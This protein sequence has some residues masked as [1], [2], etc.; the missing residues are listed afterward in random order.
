M[1]ATSS[2]APKVGD[3]AEPA[4]AL[5][6]GLEGLRIRPAHRELLLRALL[7][8]LRDA[9][10]AAEPRFLPMLR[11]TVPSPLQCTFNVFSS[12]CDF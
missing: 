7:E 8:H 4:L 9:A 5:L 10:P 6:F 1:S 2:L 3:G 12:R 11:W